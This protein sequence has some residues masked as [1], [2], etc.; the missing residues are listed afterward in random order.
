MTQLIWDAQGQ[1]RYETGVDHGVLY[2]PDG[3]GAF[4]NGVAWNGLT[5]VT[6][7][8][9]GAESNKQYA[10]NIPYLN[11][12]SAEE[13]S[14]TLEC[15][16]YP[17]EWAEF[18]GFAEP[19]PGVVVGQQDRRAFGLSYRTILG[20]DLL[21]NAY[22][23]K[24]HLVYNATATPS[25]RAYTTVND[26]PEAITFSWEMTT[27]PV[28]VTGMKPTALLVIDTTK[29]DP[30]ALAALL[31]ALHGTAGT[32][33]RLPLPDEVITM[34]AGS[35]TEVTPVEPA[36]VSATGV[37]T[38][39]TVTG[40]R[41]RRA[42]TLA[43]VAGGSTVTIATPG[44]SLVITAEPTSGAYSFTPMSDDDWSFTRDL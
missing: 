39:P 2:I 18:D 37:I 38:I 31:E 16:T 28:A 27:I 43:I 40:V 30:T 15:F 9:S 1:R 21:G 29:A 7:T 17:D 26:S 8:P 42:D 44:D 22:G 11:L 34:F 3:A 25:E 24:Y 6:E 35:V 14:A 33:P 32:D 36:F 13:F 12:T 41:Y 10:D 23:Y 20:N 4:P 5:G 19:E